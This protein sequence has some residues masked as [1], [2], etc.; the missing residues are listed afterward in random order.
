MKT[1]VNKLVS[2]LIIISLLLSMASCGKK[3]NSRSEKKISEDSPWFTSNIVDCESGAD[4]DKNIEYLNY[5]LAGVDDKYYVVFARGRYAMPPQD[6]IDYDNFDYNSFNF[7]V[8][9]V[10]DKNT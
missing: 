10:V 2:T 4:P 8:V 5:D 1:S 9:S 6:E 3:N 7:G